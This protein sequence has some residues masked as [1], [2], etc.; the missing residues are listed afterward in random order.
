MIRKRFVE[1]HHVISAGRCT[2]LARPYTLCLAETWLDEAEAALN[3]QWQITLAHTRTR[4]GA[5]AERRLRKQQR[6]WLRARDRECAAFGRSTPVTQASRNELSC[7]AHMDKGRTAYLRRLAKPD[8][9]FPPVIAPPFTTPTNQFLLEAQPI[10]R[11]LNAGVIVEL[12][13]FLGAVAHDFSI[14]DLARSAPIGRRR[15]PA[16]RRRRDRRPPARSTTRRFG[17]RRRSPRT[18]MSSSPNAL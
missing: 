11:L 9:E 12:G 18:R 2:H 3:A 16:P 1:Y 15:R 10:T 14:C 7:S 13:Q 17:I 8:C 5:G 4:G 6:Q